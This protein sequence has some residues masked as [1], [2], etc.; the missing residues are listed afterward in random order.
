MNVCRESP[1]LVSVR[2][3]DG[4]ALLYLSLEGAATLMGGL[5]D[6]IDVMRPVLKEPLAPIIPLAPPTKS[7]WS[8]PPIPTGARTESRVPPAH[9]AAFADGRVHHG[10]RAAPVGKGKNRGKIRRDSRHGRHRQA[11]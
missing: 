11:S 7:Q 6:A 9:G 3:D 1:T 10:G 8:R 4:K 5:A 2:G